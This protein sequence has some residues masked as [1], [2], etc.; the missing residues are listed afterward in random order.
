[1]QIC[2]VSS[3]RVVIDRENTAF[4]G[5]LLR[6]S[7]PGAA[8]RTRRKRGEPCSDS[9]RGGAD[10]EPARVVSARERV[11]RDGGEGGRE[12]GEEPPKRTP[13]HAPRLRAK[14]PSVHWPTDTGA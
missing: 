5:G 13:L 8:E 11:G 3:A 2:W 1:S 6:G 14:T 12:T 7:A 4:P 9:E 10:H